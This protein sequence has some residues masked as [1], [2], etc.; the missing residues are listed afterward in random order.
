ML[1]HGGR[2]NFFAKQY[3]RPVADWLDLST[4]INPHGWPVPAL[5]AHLW[6][7]LPE[8]DDDLMAAASAYYQ[9]QHLLALPGSQAAIQLLPLLRD[10]S[11]VGILAPAYAE[12]AYCWQQAGHQLVYLS[13]T[14]IAKQLEYLDVLIIINPNNPTGETFTKQDLLDWHQQLQLRGGWLIVDEAFIDAT[15]Q[16]SLIAEQPQ[17]GLIV[18]RSLGK[19]FGLAGLRVGFVHAP[20]TILQALAHA[21]GPWS[22]AT[23]SRYIA[24][25][26]LR[27][28]HWQQQT[29]AELTLASTRLAT[30]L[31]EFFSTSVNGSAL[32]QWIQT[33]QASALHA[34]LAQHGILSRLFEHPASLRFGLPRTE[35]DWQRLRQVLVALMSPST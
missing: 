1:E 18:L 23:A 30:L 4:G 2:L 21:A 7:R 13:V 31:A 14:Q 19:F 34:R 11:R 24:A 28:T 8:D 5:P 15:P 35:Q 6:S 32:F 3:Q 26:A 33:E 22:I 16:A 9:S 12:H 17:D 25:Q 27:D 10:K 20:A 29:C